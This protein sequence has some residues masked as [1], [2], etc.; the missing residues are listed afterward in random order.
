MPT[1]S[2]SARG[3]LARTRAATRVAAMATFT[4][5]MLGGVRAHQQLSSELERYD[6]YQGWMKRWCQGLLRIFGVEVTLASAPASA[7]MSARLVVA[8]HRSPLDIPILLQHFGG[9][10]LSRADLATWPVLGVAAR[11]AET[12]FVDR[13]DTMSGVAAARTIRERL[14]RGRTVIVFPEGTTHAGDQVHT[15]HEG[16]FAAARGLTLELVPV[17][18][19]YEAGS[20][21]VEPSFGAH[22]E[23]VAGRPKTRVAVVIGASRMMEGSRKQVAATLHED[24][25]KLVRRARGELAG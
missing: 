1:L 20:E 8:N 6:V 12:I 7:A 17:G 3:A 2:E 4:L 14:L 23:R 16:A 11:S 5:G 10:V 24:I 15:F 21:F 19:A 25:Q 9:V 13:A 18:I 22:L